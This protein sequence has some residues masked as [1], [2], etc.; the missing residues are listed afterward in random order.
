VEHAE[1]QSVVKRS[2]MLDKAGTLFW[3]KGYHD[4]SMW[5]IAEAC[6]CKPA[7]IYHYFKGKEDILYSVVLDI[8]EQ[9]V[10]CIKH[11]K[12]DNVTS[13]VEQ[14][15]SLVKNHFGLW[16]SMKRSNVLISDTGLRDLSN[17]HR[18][19]IIALRDEYDDIMCNIIRRGIDS[20][21]FVVNDEKVVTY[22]ISSVILRSSIWFSPKGRL[23][24]DEVGD[25]MFDLVY[26][27]IKNPKSECNPR[28]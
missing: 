10:S 19:T 4:T 21:D 27:G 14:L 18:K 26:R 9:T 28:S 24:A 15:R 5:D 11:L 1:K 16:V 6:E 22:L 23:S 3:E 12:D 25:M 17:E 2:W 8:T 7:N 13:P 20:G